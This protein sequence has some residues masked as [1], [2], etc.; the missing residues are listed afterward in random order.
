M[1][2]FLNEKI[3][4]SGN[5][6]WNKLVQAD[7]DD[8]IIPA[9][10]TPEHKYNL[11]I[12][13]R[14]MRSRWGEKNTWGFGIN[15]KWIQG[16]LFEGS[17]QFTGNVPSYDLLDAQVNYIVTS[18]NTTFKIGASNLM[19]NMQF[20]TYGGPRIGRLAYF[21]ILYELKTN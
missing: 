17:P 15:Y 8:P 6:S 11:G 4:L 1:N 19:N 20:Q 13:A 16:F 18:I 12:T 7:E 3:S 5:Y 14:D 21:S 2:Y 9:F 10:N